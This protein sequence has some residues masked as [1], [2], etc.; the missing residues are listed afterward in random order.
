MQS[1]IDDVSS[2]DS[3]GFAAASATPPPFEEILNR[4]KPTTL[5]DTVALAAATFVFVAYLL[6]GY[7]WDKPDPYGYIFYERPQATDGDGAHGGTRRTRNIAE[8]LEE[9]NK[10][11]VVFWGSQSGTAE[12]FANRLSR[13][14]H[15]RLGLDAMAADLSDFEPETIA[16]IP[17]SKTAIL[18]LS[19]YGEG[20]P[21]DNATQF[22]E[23]LIKAVEG[24]NSDSATS[25]LLG[26]LKYAAFG[27]GNS[28]Y[29]YYNRVVDV[30]DDAFVA[31][32]AERLLP[33]GQADDSHGATEED[34][35][36]WKDSLFAFFRDHFGIQEREP[37]YEPTVD[38]VEDDSLQQQ[39]LYD[40][41][42]VHPPEGSGFK[43]VNSPVKALK[44]RNAKELFASSSGRN[45]LHM[46]LDITDHPQLTY[47]TGDHLA[48]W[49][50][51]PNQEVDRLL[52]VL[53]LTSRRQSPVIVRALDPEAVKV[54]VPTPTS[55]EALLRYYL[56]ICAAVPRDVVRGL[57]EFAPTPA[58]RDFLH[59]LGKDKD[60][61]GSF[62]S[63]TH[64]NLGKLLELAT[65]G[66]STAVWSNLPLSYLVDA[67]PRTQPR[68]YSIS[69]SSIISPRAPAIT[70]LVSSTPLTPPDASIPGLTTNYLLALSDYLP[71]AIKTANTPSPMLTYNLPGPSD[72]LSG[73]LVYGHIRRSKFKLPMQASC[74]L[75]MI[76][77]GT[78]LAP[79][80]AFI[81]ERARLQSIGKKSGKI[82]LFFG[83]RN[84]EEDFIYSDELAQLEEGDLKGTLRVVT[85]FSRVQGSP[86][87]Y[88]QD[89][90]RELGSEVVEMLTQESAS[91]YICG[92][93]SMAREVGKA[94]GDLVMDRR[95]DAGES[96]FG[97]NQTKQ[98][99]EG[100]K[101]TR[102][103]QEDVWG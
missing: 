4:M 62:L 96:S 61:Y 38:V 37:K 92:R 50:M 57:A 45:C 75:I 39:D 84:P 8:R 14:L 13:E 29:Q 48:V 1:P 10:D 76:A 12:G 71:E 100:M 83:C 63:H 70:A 81:S 78:G 99:R 20:D 94:V 7:L 55:I 58:A 67:L 69:S 72:A 66:D 19:T 31:C 97:E 36:E 73:G 26:S 35:L 59:I 77:A 2:P 51:N 54:K 21:S 64:I 11:V 25:A 89:K 56:E 53:G 88:V 85:A 68:F 102:K 65:K 16:Q 43:Q 93:A 32:G 30:V 28:D 46:D 103:W 23:W 49:P 52:R 6:R 87:L 82:L 40:G 98:W 3:S 34:F 24:K 86:K 80:R 90:V 17:R 33:T 5:S 22:W 42:P 101:R 15:Q 79:F 47:K 27:L 60:S 18:I 41:E 9:L 91:M 44:I 74:P 95:K